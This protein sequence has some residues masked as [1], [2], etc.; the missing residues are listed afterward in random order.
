MNVPVFAS[1][2][3]CSKVEPS[4][5]TSWWSTV[6]GTGPPSAFS[7]SC[8]GRSK[9]VTSSSL[10]RSPPPLQ[11]RP[12]GPLEDRDV[13]LVGGLAAHDAAALPHPRP[14]RERPVGAGAE[15]ALLPVRQ[16]VEVDESL[17][18]VVR[19]ARDRH[20]EVDSHHGAR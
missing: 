20:R 3:T 13:E 9:T 19:R 15:R 5:S 12:R 14:L 7:V 17:E 6:N 4:S 1:A 2:T 10:F 16:P 8:R 11:R 18:N